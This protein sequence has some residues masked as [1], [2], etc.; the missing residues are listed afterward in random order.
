M[1]EILFASDASN[2]IVVI[3]QVC[4]QIRLLLIELQ[5]AYGISLSDEIAILDAYLLNKVWMFCFIITCNKRCTLILVDTTAA[6]RQ[7]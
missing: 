7:F 1:R 2:Y 6:W 4:G 3:L 5:Q